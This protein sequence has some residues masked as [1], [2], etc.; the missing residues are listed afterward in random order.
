[1]D[2]QE[3]IKKVSQMDSSSIYRLP[4]EAEWE[5]VCRSGSSA[6]FSN[7]DLINI[8]CHKDNRLDEIAWYRCNSE[9]KTHPVGQKVPNDWGIYDMHGNVSEWCQDVYVTN[10]AQI[11]YGEVED[12]DI[13]ADRVS[14]NC[15]YDDTAVSCRSAARVNFQPDVRS[16]VIGFRLV[17]EPLY[18]KIKMPPSGEKLKISDKTEKELETVQTE[19]P[20]QP[21]NLEKKNGFTL[22]VAAMKNKKNADQMMA[23]LEEKGYAANI[24]RVEMAEKGTWFIIR[25]GTYK[26]VEEA[27]KM[28]MNLV[29]D[30]IQSI[31]VKNLDSD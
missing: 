26:S 13:I 6:A 9:G 12:L 27:K 16:S 24:L 21:G 23:Q 7:G 1:L 17:R 30:S 18:Y 3:F 11:I 14:R 15:S 28:Q 19:E 20:D 5:Y 31:I 29:E 8:E 10:Y 22:Q 4:T 2:I 25:I